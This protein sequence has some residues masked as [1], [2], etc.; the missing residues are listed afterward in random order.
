M[1]FHTRVYV[2][3]CV[4]VYTI[5]SEIRWSW[6]KDVIVFLGL[7]VH[8]AIRNS[9]GKV[10]ILNLYFNTLWFHPVEITIRRNIYQV[11]TSWSGKE[12][13]GEK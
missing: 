6:D 7:T 11:G 13:G 8:S 10:Q 5:C 2:C 4:Y 9:G 1:P 12:Q 3:A